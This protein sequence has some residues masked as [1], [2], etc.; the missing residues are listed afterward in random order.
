MRRGPVAIVPAATRFA[1]ECSSEFPNRKDFSR[2][3]FGR[4]AS[5][6]AL[7]FRA[8][9]SLEPVEIRNDLRSPARQS[10]VSSGSES[11]EGGALNERGISA[12]KVCIGILIALGVLAHLGAA[13]VPGNRLTT[14]WSGGGD[15]REYVELARNLASGDGYTFAQ[16]PTAFRAPVYPLLLAGLMRIAPTDWPLILRTLQFLA[17]V[18][19]ALL[20]GILAARWFGSQ[21]KYVTV[22]IALLLPTLIYFTGEILTECFAALLS[23]LFFVLLDAAETSGQTSTLLALGGVAGVAALERFNTIALIPIAVI[24]VFFCG[25]R[26]AGRWFRAVAVAAAAMVVLAPWLIHN[27][28]SFH[29]QATYS[30][31]GGFAA[32]EGIVMPLG[33]TQTGETEE[34]H[35]LLG[36]GNW[37][38][39]TDS[40]VRPEFRNEPA[41]NSQAWQVAFKLWKQ[42]S[43]RF[44]PL[45]A[46]KLSAFWL[47]TDQVLDIPY[48]SLR[49]RLTRIAGVGIYLTVLALAVVGW[50]R[51]RARK[52]RVA[53]TIA[54]SAVVL[55][56]FH[57]LLTMNTRLRVP[58]F[59]PL[60]AALAGYAVTRISGLFPKT[61][62][63]DSPA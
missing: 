47:S 2:L 10:H 27:E 59:D 51:L 35:R 32:V 28:L 8:V 52:P 4:T 49:G 24:A 37:D 36:W 58:L 44:I 15:T 13:I 19:T 42:E 25:P 55:T 43:W 34:I 7:I 23:I 50:L 38:V 3:V 45:F 16:Q 62:S 54:S 63:L 60:L 30:T 39:E 22:A 33:R 11:R 29:G 17:S 53:R 56:I 40:P 20:C 12:S 46:N 21:A 1:R 9:Q 57:L 31:H 26:N 61:S 41:L 48:L 14:P 6:A 5:C 18:A